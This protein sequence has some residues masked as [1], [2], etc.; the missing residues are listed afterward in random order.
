M[1]K[2]D[3]I[4]FIRKPVFF[5][6]MNLDNSNLALTLFFFFSYWCHVSCSRRYSQTRRCSI[7]CKAIQVAACLIIKTEFREAQPWKW[8][9]L[10]ELS[11]CFA[12]ANI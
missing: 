4:I 1:K 7:C 8:Q 6:N 10:I 11:L 3:P 2:K 5:I 9:Q 12:A